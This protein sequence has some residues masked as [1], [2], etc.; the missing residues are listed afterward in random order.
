MIV[1]PIE[2]VDANEFV[3]LHHRHHKPVVGHRFSV[4]AW[5]NDRLCGVAIVGRPVARLAGSPLEVAEVTRLCSD[6]TPHVCSMLYAAAARACKAIGF[7]RIQTYVL[8][9]EAGVTLK[10]AGW[11]KGNVTI[12][13]SWNRVGETAGLW[14]SNRRTDQPMCNKVRWFKMLNNTSNALTRAKEAK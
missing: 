2:L 9:S 3:A 5:E 11:T 8:E 1:R 7:L 13:K 4:S 10:A 14:G 12:G 6:G